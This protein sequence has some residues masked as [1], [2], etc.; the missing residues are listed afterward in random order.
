LKS[1][2]TKPELLL[3]TYL[4]ALGLRY[5][6]HVGDLP[7]TPDIVFGPSRVAVFVHGCFWHRHSPCVVERSNSQLSAEWLRRLNHSVRRDAHV[8]AELENAGWYVFVAWE[9][10]LNSSPMEQA[11]AIERVVERR[12]PRRWPRS[13]ISDLPLDQ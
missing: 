8:R 2:N 3:R 12:R 6:L 10:E 13:V 4:T 5:R 1:K 11:R 7:G 9:C